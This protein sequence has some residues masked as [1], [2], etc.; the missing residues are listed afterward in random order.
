LK[1]CSSLEE[2]PISIHKSHAIENLH[3]NNYSRLQ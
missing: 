3:L 2:L 1:E